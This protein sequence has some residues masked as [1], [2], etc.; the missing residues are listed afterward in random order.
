[1]KRLFIVLCLAIP[2]GATD[3]IVKICRDAIVETNAQALEAA[4]LVYDEYT[5][6]TFTGKQIAAALRSSAVA[7]RRK[8]R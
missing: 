8:S 4:A 3:S 2:A 5:D 7:V 6:T 1:M